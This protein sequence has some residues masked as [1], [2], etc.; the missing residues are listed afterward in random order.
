MAETIKFLS[1]VLL[2][3]H[4]AKRLAGFYR[5]VLGIPLEEER[6]TPSNLHWGCNLGDVHF[7]IHP[8]ADFED[9]PSAGVGAIKLAFGVDDIDE[10]AD[11]LESRGVEL[12]YPPRDLGWCKMTAVRDP[13]GNYVELTELGADWYRHLEK[14]KDENPS[15]PPG[16]EDTIRNPRWRRRP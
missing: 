3:S 11:T 15:T 10:T 7:A 16:S 5:D 14:R 1:A 12:V 4:D 6:H 9:D 2:V 8:A 13:D